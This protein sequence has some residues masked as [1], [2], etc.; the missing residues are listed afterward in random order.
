MKPSFLK[1]IAIVF[2]LAVLPLTI[3]TAQ[4]AVKVGS[5]V[6]TWKPST[7][8]AVGD[9]IQKFGKCLVGAVLDL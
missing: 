3:S 7:P 1:S 5:Y 2:T 8:Y 6:G 9:L 4:A